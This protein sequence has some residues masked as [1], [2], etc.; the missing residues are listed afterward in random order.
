MG[1][2]KQDLS[3]HV[4]R[5]SPPPLF[6]ALDRFE[7]RSQKLGEFLLSLSQIGPDVGKFDI[8]HLADSC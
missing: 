5:D 3:L 1:Q 4:H 8:T 7:R 6:K 2:K